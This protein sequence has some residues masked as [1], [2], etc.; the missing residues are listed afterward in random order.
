MVEP[1]NYIDYKLDLPRIPDNLLFKTIDEIQNN[2]ELIWD[3]LS[4]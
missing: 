3:L 4:L 1:S 2:C